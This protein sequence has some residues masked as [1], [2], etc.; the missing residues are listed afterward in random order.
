MS[1][2]LGI[3]TSNYTT[4]AAIYSSD[5]NS[6]VQNKKLLPV[7][8]GECGLR[9]SDAVFHHTNQLSGILKDLLL[10]TEKL[11]AVGVST[12]P[13]NLE[14]SYMPCFLTGKTAAEIITYTSGAELFYTSHQLG[15]VAVALYSCNRL[16]LLNEKFIAFHVSGGTTD[17]IFCNPDDE[18]IID[19]QPF[20]GSLD[21]KAGQAVDRVG[22]MLGLKFPCGIELEKLAEKSDKKFKINIKLKGNDCCL[23]GIENKCRKMLDDGVCK[24]DIA[25]YCLEYIAGTIKAMTEKAI[26]KLGEYPVVYA[27]GVMSDKLIRKR[28]E[29]NFEAYFAQ[30]EFSCDNAAGVAIIAA[31]KFKRKNKKC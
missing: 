1:D 25:L 16:D 21:L 15:H 24:E 19:A 3:D 18:E 28:L 6:I 10:S 12:C 11:T 8:E 31:E 4:S 29:N 27:G 22:V 30:P 7:K 23:S 17:C 14:G 13:R 5:T 26:E 2:F 9:Q 20:S